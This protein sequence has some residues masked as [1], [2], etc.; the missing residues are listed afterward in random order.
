MASVQARQ[1]TKA[2]TPWRRMG[3]SPLSSLTTNGISWMAENRGCTSGSF[4]AIVFTWDRAM[5]SLLADFCRRFRF[6]ASCPF[7][8]RH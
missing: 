1:L 5:A 7:R 4:A 6:G 2:G 8:G 3:L